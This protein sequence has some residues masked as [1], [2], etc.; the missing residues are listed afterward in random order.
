MAKK[1]LDE[2]ILTG[3]SISAD[4]NSS[5]KKAEK[6]AKKAEKA[7]EKNKK[8]KEKLEAKRSAVKSQIDALKEKKAKET[9]S[10]KIKALDEQIKKLSNKYSSIGSNAGGLAPQTVKII[11]SAICIVVVVAL[12][13]TYVATGAVRKG[14]IASLSL[15]AQTFT[16]MTVSNGTEKAR[17]KVSTYNFYFASTYNSLQSQKEQYSQYGIDPEQLG[18]DVDFDK[19]LSKQEYTDKETNETM[20]WAKHLEELVLD[21]IES[22]YTYYLAAVAANDGEEPEIT[23]AQKAEIDEALET[24]EKTANQYGYTLSGYLVRA[25][26]KGVTEKVFRT[27]STRQ[28]IAQNYQGQINTDLAEKGYSDDDLNAYKDEHL[29]ALKTVDIKIFE[30]DSEDNA[31]AFAD[32][33]KADGSNFADLAAKYSTTD[34]D[35]KINA[36]ASS[37]YELG[38]TRTDLINRSYAIAAADPHEHEEG[39][40]HS[41]DEETTYS[42]LDWLFSSDRKAG[43]IRQQSTSVVYVVAPASLSDRNTVNVRHILIAP[44]TD[45]ENTSATEA[46]DEQW[47][48]AYEKADSILN[49]WKSG[50]ATEDSFAQLAKENSTD[51]GA[52]ETGGL[53]ENVI[54]GQMVDQFSAWCFSSQRKAG[55][56]DIVQTNYGYHIMYFVG[57]NDEKVWQYNARQALASDDG[58]SAAE[59]L[60]EEYTLKVNWFGSRYFEKDVDIDN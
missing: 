33:L 30:C 34:F 59:K 7:A 37:T 60:E 49:E 42:G 54:T 53:Y 9:D 2:D 20:T 36:Y 24:Y 57:T 31:K 35:K 41:D 3:G 5:D 48:A 15:P 10:E 55:D 11:K 44:E 29:D 6:A 16:G 19:P 1:N 45:D 4:K 27:E 21:S 58:T 25:M 13:V 40:E 17:I 32:E 51:T 52:S 28:Y 47:A 22:T 26:G 14:F 12:L 56:T 43:D 18:L 46:T 38:M 8:N 39:E 23:E 50:E